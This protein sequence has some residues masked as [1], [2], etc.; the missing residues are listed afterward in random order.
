[1]ANHRRIAAA[2]IDAISK[3]TATKSFEHCLANKAEA[4]ASYAKR[5]ALVEVQAESASS[6]REMASSG[7][8]H[9]RTH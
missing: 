8:D 5:A 2:R 1:V 6:A 9:R 7:E 4:V 3:T